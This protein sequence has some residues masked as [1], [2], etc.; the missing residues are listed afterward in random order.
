MLTQNNFNY[1]VLII[2]AGFTGLS[3]AYEIAKQGYKV[4]VC[5]QQKSLGGLAGSYCLDNGQEL[6]KFYHHWF[7]NDDSILEFAEELGLSDQLEYSNS[8]T[9]CFWQGKLYK[10]SSVLDLLRFQPL[11]FVDRIRLGI[12]VPKTR[13]IKNWQ[14]L[15]SITAEQWLIKECGENVFKR[16]WQPLLKGK[17][18][19]YASDV[20]AVW[21]WNKIKLRGNSRDRN[22]REVL[23]YPRNGFSGFTNHIAEKIQSLGGDVFVDSCVNE[24]VVKD[25]RIDKIVTSNKVF[26]ARYVIATTPLSVLS[27]LLRDHVPS[28]YIH[29]LHKIKHLANLCVVL[30]LALPLSDLYWINVSDPSFPFVGIIEHTNFRDPSFCGNRRIVYLSCYLEDTDSFFL[31]DSDEVYKKTMFHLKKVFPHF[32]EDSV[33]DFN[34]FKCRDAQPIVGLNHSQIIPSWESPLG[35]LFLATMAQVYP[36]DRGTNYAFKEGKR[37]GQKIAKLLSLHDSVIL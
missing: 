7:C 33:I 37:A 32:H 5:E 24:F 20:S 21:F 16:V 25:R 3:A 36:E 2:G 6:E 10:L 11:N 29:N 23:V 1:D 35:N 27:R 19:P 4:A 17:F 15:E 12:L 34:V 26:E 28:S 8:K 13:L 30:E 14:K 22:G 18:G 31:M 9:G